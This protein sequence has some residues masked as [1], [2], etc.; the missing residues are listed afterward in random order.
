MINIAKAYI[1]T[2]GNL[3]YRGCGVNYY[4]FSMAD[5]PNKFRVNVNVSLHH[6]QNNYVKSLALDEFFDKEDAAINYGV[7]QGKRFIDHAY[8][9][10][11]VSIVAPDPAIK[12]KNDKNEKASKA[13]SDKAKVDKK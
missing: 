13:K 12:A 4:T 7:D 1:K 9:L 11:K 2:E 6:T 10:G 5:K 8:E 3:E